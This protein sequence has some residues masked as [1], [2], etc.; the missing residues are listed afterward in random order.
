MGAKKEKRKKA[1]KKLKEYLGIKP[2]SKSKPEGIVL[3]SKGLRY[4]KRF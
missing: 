2:K 1:K 4:I 3:D